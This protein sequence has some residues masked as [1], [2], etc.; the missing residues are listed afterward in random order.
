MASEREDSQRRVIPRFRHAATSAA[1][2]ERAAVLPREATGL[3]SREWLH[4][5]RRDF[6]EQPSALGASELLGTARLLGDLESEARA[7]AWLSQYA[8]R[9]YAL[10][11]PTAPSGAANLVSPDRA[12]PSAAMK[13]QRAIG[14][15][16]R[17]LA[18]AP[19][20]P[21]SWSE[22]ARLYLIC[23]NKKKAINAI[24]VAIG[25]GGHHRYIYRCASRLFIHFGEKERA[26]S[27]LRSHPGLKDDPWLLSAEIAASS[28]LGKVSP[29]VGI[30]TK[31]LHADL[32]ARSTVELAAAIATVEQD[33]GH[34]M[35]ARKLYA[36]CG[37]SDND[38][39]IAQFEWA[40]AKDKN[41]RLEPPVV[42]SAMS[43]AAARRAFIDQRWSEV[44]P[45]CLRWVEDEQ[46]SSRPVLMGTY[47]ASLG[48]ASG[49]AE[50][51][52]LATHGI[53][54]DRTDPALYNNRAVLRAN[55]FNIQGA[56]EDV[57][58]AIG[59][60]STSS[61][62][63]N[64]AT[65]GLIAYR[66]RNFELGRLCYQKSLD[67]LGARGDVT[68]LLICALFLAREENR[69]SKA[70]SMPILETASRLMKKAAIS[71]SSE[72]TAMHS[73]ITR[74][75]PSQEPE[76]R[77]MDATSMQ[78]IFPL[79]QKIAGTLRIDIDDIRALHDRVPTTTAREK[80]GSER[81][82]TPPSIEPKYVIRVPPPN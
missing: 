21:L 75:P 51:E 81:P 2:G 65:L 46:F 72:L 12:A 69:H 59:G 40:R 74:E 73:A 44:L 14:E 45:A 52:I 53:F 62:P 58:V 22:L 79:V 43:E 66:M 11:P 76:L 18:N 48:L 15:C 31:L 10:K 37:D 20:S 6:D 29:Y 68:S 5:Q 78:K 23:G 77:E 71:T 80:S 35:L 13:Y 19:N 55:Q 60:E 34:R 30:G 39:A 33:H 7:L 54:A 57:E 16:R 27:L 63:Y 41:L 49:Y 38:N 47:I 61:L 25:L 67:I 8:P 70:C 26:L 17:Q 42:T 28:V 4:S 24:I 3:R 56:L 9:S 1:L 64:L 36:R 50:G 32:P 82:M